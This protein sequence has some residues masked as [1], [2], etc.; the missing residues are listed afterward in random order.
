MSVTQFDVK[1]GKQVGTFTGLA[2]AYGVQD[3]Q[4]DTIAPGAFAKSIAAHN[5]VPILWQHESDNPIGFGTL[6]DGPRGLTI[7]GEL[8]LDITE[9]RTAYSAIKKGYVKGLSIGYGVV[10]QAYE[11]GVRKLLEITL[12]EVSI[13]TFPANPLALVAEVKSAGPARPPRN[14]MDALG[15]ILTRQNAGL[16]ADVARFQTRSDERRLPLALVVLDLKLKWLEAGLRAAFLVD[17]L[18]QG[19]Y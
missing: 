16:W 3:S 17:A 9:G 1:A 14:P 12:W 7:N 18:T 6:T 10:K 13:A 11:Q 2:A 15:Q 19:G 4:G 8:D 5:T